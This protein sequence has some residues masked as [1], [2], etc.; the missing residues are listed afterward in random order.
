MNSSGPE[1]LYAAAASHCGNYARPW[2]P[3][4]GEHHHGD[5]RAR[6][7]GFYRRPRETRRGPA[8]QLHRSGITAARHHYGMDNSAHSNYLLEAG[9]VSRDGLPSADIPRTPGAYCWRHLDRPVYVA[10]TEDLHRQLKEL[11]TRARQRPVPPFRQFARG[12]AQLMGTPGHGESKEERIAAI[13]AYIAECSVAWCATETFEDAQKQAREAAQDLLEVDLWHPRPGEDGW[14]RR[15]LDGRDDRGRVYVEVPIGGSAGRARR[16]DA[17]RF[18]G[19]EGGVRYFDRS[20]FDTD[21]QQ[22]RCEVIEVKRTL[23]R[24]VIGQLIVARELAAMEWSRD[25][26]KQLTLIALVTESDPALEPI[27]QRHGIQVHVV[28]RVPE[29]A[30]NESDLEE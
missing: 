20:S 5:D 8:E 3:A 1:P 24:A 14:L 10:A 22:H 16:I 11:D 27:C 30:T 23:N 12:Q 29:D 7:Q 4:A 25:P 19:L 18:P 13:D 9:G 6:G 28:S 15:Y 2:P 26:S 17:V 21:V